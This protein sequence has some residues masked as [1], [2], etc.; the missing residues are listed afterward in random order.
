MMSLHQEYGEIVRIHPD[1]LSVVAPAWHDIHASRPS[2]PKPEVGTLR[3][4]NRAPSLVTARSMKEHDR[5]RLVLSYGFSERALKEQEPIIQKYVDLLIT[6]LMH[7][8]IAN[9]ENGVVTLNVGEWYSFTT[10]DIIGDLS[11]GESFHSLE[12]SRHH[13]WVQSSCRGIKFGVLMTVFDH[14]GLARAVVYKCIPKPIRLKA[15]TFAEFSRKRIDERLK[16]DSDRP[17]FVSFILRNKDKHYFTRHE[18]DSN[19]SLLIFAGSETTA[20]A[21]T[22]ATWF[23]LKNPAT[24]KR[25]QKE[26]RGNFAAV[27]DITISAVSPLPY[28]HAV[29]QEAMRLHPTP[30]VALP[31]EVDRPGV[32]VYGQEIPMGV[33]IQRRITITRSRADQVS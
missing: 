30:P 26:V 32:I 2:L 31:R 23:L 27:G 12:N 21:C 4:P 7:Q 16:H 8:S 5:M 18:I 20:T 11:F 15:Q 9:G 17:D 33:S 29:I 19:V 24:L 14:F 13:E 6:Q 22:S 1:E 10:F 25:L 3:T 28:L